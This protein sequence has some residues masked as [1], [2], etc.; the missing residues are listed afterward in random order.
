M[1]FCWN[2]F[3]ETQRIKRVD[4]VIT[5]PSVKRKK[6]RASFTEPD[7][8]LSGCYADSLLNAF[9]ERLFEGLIVGYLIA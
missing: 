8:E 5:K 3:Q 4:S 9:A 2:D 7:T 1:R 6:S